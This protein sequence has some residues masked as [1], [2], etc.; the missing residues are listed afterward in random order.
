MYGP[1][2]DTLRGAADEHVNFTTSGFDDQFGGAMRHL[3]GSVATLGT[4]A[5]MVTGDGA[6]A[7]DTVDKEMNE[8]DIAFKAGQQ[9][10]DGALSVAGD[11]LSGN[12]SVGV[13]RAKRV[14]A[15]LNAALVAMKENYTEFQEMLPHLVAEG[16]KV[17]AD[18]A[19]FGSQV[20][21]ERVHT[22]V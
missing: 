19:A 2:A 20:G 15:Q 21:G 5:A 13:Q 22:Y 3:N 17:L 16:E 4:T 18:L 12:A 14:A 8:T 11:D 6:A 1:V 7:L 10:L 9:V